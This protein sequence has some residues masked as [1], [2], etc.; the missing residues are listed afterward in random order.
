MTLC[1][2]LPHIPQ[3]LPPPYWATPLAFHSNSLLTIHT[4][5]NNQLQGTSLMLMPPHLAWAP[6]SHPHWASVPTWRYLPCLVLS[7]GYWIELLEK[8]K[9]GVLPFSA[10]VI[11]TNKD[12]HIYLTHIY[13]TSTIYIWGTIIGPV[14]LCSPPRASLLSEEP[15]IS[16]LITQDVFQYQV[17]EKKI[18]QKVA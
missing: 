5:S 7:N 16:L 18:H 14:G 17:I 6:I 10:S 13:S 1:I 2:C 12:N 3:A 9:K 8:E 4:G 11:N 15:T